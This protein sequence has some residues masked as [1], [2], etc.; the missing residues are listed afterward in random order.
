MFACTTE[1]EVKTRTKP[2]V[3]DKFCLENRFAPCEAMRQAIERNEESWDELNLPIE[4]SN[5]TAETEL[6]HV[7][8]GG[9]CDEHTLYPQSGIAGMLHAGE[10]ESCEIMPIASGTDI[11]MKTGMVYWGV[12]C[13]INFRDPDSKDQVAKDIKLKIRDYF[14]AIARQRSQGRSN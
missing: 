5:G 7:C 6:V 3:D 1:E 10:F 4:I 12:L 11:A 13:P 2:I 14:L 8:A 9:Y